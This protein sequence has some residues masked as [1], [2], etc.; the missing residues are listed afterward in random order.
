MIPEGCSVVQF[1]ITMGKVEE[2]VNK[3]RMYSLISVNSNRIIHNSLKMKDGWLYLRL[4]P[5]NPF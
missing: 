4:Q 2:S 1:M 3:N 5:S